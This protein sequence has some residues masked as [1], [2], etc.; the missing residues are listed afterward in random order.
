MFISY[1]AI[2]NLEEYLA[3]RLSLN[4]NLL[5]EVVLVGL[6]HS[7]MLVHTTEF[8]H[9]KQFKEIKK[10]LMDIMYITKSLGRSENNNWRPWGHKN[11]IQMTPLDSSHQDSIAA[12]SRRRHHSFHG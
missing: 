4:E 12:A 2:Q 9:S 10:F 6:C 11:N 3:Q 5:L 1:G 7:E 8:T